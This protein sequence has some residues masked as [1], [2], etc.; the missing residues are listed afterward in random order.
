MEGTQTAEVRIRVNG[1]EASDEIGKLKEQIEELRKAL[2]KTNDTGE[3]SR[4]TAKIAEK[5]EALE[6]MSGKA[7]ELNGLMER[8]GEIGTEAIKVRKEELEGM[9]AEEMKGSDA[10]V[11]HMIE[12]HALASKL[13]REKGEE[14]AYDEHAW[15]EE[16]LSALAAEYSQGLILDEEYYNGKAAIMRKYYQ[17]CSGL[18]KYS[19]EEREK[20]AQLAEE[21]LKKNKFEGLTSVDY[22]ETAKVILDKQNNDIKILIKEYQEKIDGLKEQLNSKNAET[23][24]S[25]IK[26]A[27]TEI[28]QLERGIKI[29]E[30]NTRMASQRVTNM[31][32]DTEE[33]L[34]KAVKY[35]QEIAAQEKI[36]SD[37]WVYAM[38]NFYEFKE[39]LN[40]I[41]DS[42]KEVD[43]FLYNE[44]DW[45]EKRI[46]ALEAEYQ[47][48]LVT[49]T[50][51]KRKMLEI[52]RDYYRVSSTNVSMNQRQRLNYLKMAER[53]EEAIVQ[54]DN[55][56]LRQE[57]REERMAAIKEVN[58]SYIESY[59][60]LQER[61]ND[62]LL[63]EYTYEEELYQL[64]KARYEGLISASKEN[65]TYYANYLTGLRNLEQKHA[66]KQQE[67]YGRVFGRMQK[68]SSYEYAQ[69]TDESYVNEYESVKATIESII[70][71][72]KKIAE[73]DVAAELINEAEYEEKLNGIEEESVRFMGEV[74]R[75]FEENRGKGKSFMDCFLTDSDIAA[76][77]E[78][79]ETI[80]G[81]A[82]T[83]MTNFASIL[84][85]VGSLFQAECDI[86]V[87]AVE[88]KYDAQLEKTK[89][90]TKKYQRLEK[91]KEAEIAKIKTKYNQ[92]AMKI[93]VAQ[94]LAQTAVNAI[95][96]YQAGL[97]FPFPANTWMPEVLAGLAVAQGMLQVAV[98]R[99]QHQAE[100]A[101][102]YRGASRSG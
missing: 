86:E 16:K 26:T 81:Y 101:G 102:Y 14:M 46:A 88:K 21:Q 40:Q 42:K 43:P 95:L 60:K 78:K 19:A 68:K 5:D 96:G 34:K 90:G 8:M 91:Q 18:M 93:E 58:E 84:S 23:N 65:L 71:K 83:F 63:T 30:T 35:W 100:T 52:E 99:Q 66:N 98:V 45:R 53:A 82:Q 17:L 57:R 24:E 92:R 1:K 2:E 87:A 9:L 41:T 12:Y 13:A 38:Q 51:Y 33:G 56:T 44:N 39:E 72:Q 10:W 80:A 4:L 97:K 61:R 49:Y 67:L 74:E 37:S 75:I 7:A 69:V 50:E 31:T 25:I 70:E 54:L 20:Y 27:I 89:S 59:N 79:F 62:G 48:D 15:M 85:S 22:K 73:Y 55:T 76:V 47:E 3:K 28:E 6:A 32:N 11:G 94:A 29:L 36:G 64:Q 77:K